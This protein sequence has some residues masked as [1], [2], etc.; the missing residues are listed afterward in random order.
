L[1]RFTEARTVLAQSFQELAPQD[2]FRRAVEQRLQRCEELLTLERRWTVLLNDQAPAGDAN[3]WFQLASVCLKHNRTYAAARLFTR[4]LAAA[5]AKAD[6]LLQGYRYQA[7]C[8]AA[9]AG[10]GHGEDAQ[11]L[12]ET[13]KA[14]LRRQALELLQ[15]DLDLLQRQYQSGEARAV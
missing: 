3:E 13:A 9:K 11:E 7:A 5:P 8:A 2:S 4:A 14:G 10:T 6:D 15:A 1:G 12:A